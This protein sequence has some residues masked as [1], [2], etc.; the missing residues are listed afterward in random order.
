[1]GQDRKQPANAGREHRIRGFAAAGGIRLRL[2]AVLAFVIAAGAVAGAVFAARSV[3]ASSSAKSQEAFRHT[4]AEV[5]VRLQLAIQRENDLVVTAAGFFL[6]DP[7][8][9]SAQFRAW[10]TSIQALRR[11]P[12][13]LSWGVIDRVAA[14][15]VDAFAARFVSGPSGYAPPV[16]SFH[17]IPA[18][19]RP[20]YCLVAALQHRPTQPAA[21]AAL[22]YCAG[23][24]LAQ[25]A[26][27]GRPV[28]TAVDLGQGHILGLDVPFYRGGVVP[29]SASARRAAFAG[30]MGMSLNPSVVLDTALLGYPRTAV[31]FRF[32]SPSAGGAFAAS[33]AVFRAGTVAAHARSATISLHNGWTV[34][35][36]GAPAVSGIL[37]NRSAVWLLI[38]GILLGIVVGLLVMVLGTG[39]ARALRLVA[40][41]TGELRHQA[42]HDALTG[43]P[44]RTLIMDRI[45]QLLLRSR[46]DGTHGAALY[47]DLD[48][49]KNVNDSLGHE[50]GDRL[51]VAV[52]SRL[53]TALRAADT[54]GRM[55]G[56]EFVVLVGGA[57]HQVAPELVA[58]RLLDVMREPFVLEGAPA[59]IIINTSIGIAAGDRACAGDLLRDADVALYQAKAAGKNRYQTFNAEMQTDAAGDIKLEFDLR[60]ALEGEQF[61]L[62]YQPIYNLDDL[63]IVGVEALLRWHHPTEGVIGPDR[64]IPTLERTGQIREVGRWVLHKACEQVAAWHARGDT[65]DISVNVSAAQLNNGAI[66]DHIRG[67]LTI[68]GL[69][70]AS[71]IIEV[72]ETALMQNADATA[73]RLRAIKKLGVRIAVDDF[74]TG[75]SSLAYLQQFPVDCLKIDRIFTDAIAT[76]PESRALIG[77][78]VQLGKDLG[79]TTL[80]EGV[81]TPAQLDHLRS[82]GVDEIQGFLLSRPLDPHALETQI[83]EPTRATG[84]PR[85]PPRLPR[86]GTAARPPAAEPKRD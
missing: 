64:F 45:D 8:A 5:A 84:A 26:D 52:A 41:R 4:S 34:Q 85:K 25:L 36:L 61:R 33:S 18:G 19:Q 77:T 73:R 2:W 86:S 9:T 16:G 37:A 76:S 60:S 10:S 82:G 66:V 69:N 24:A 22:D 65:L 46:R 49:F 50:A 23:G 39:R 7:R 15:G 30:W 42:V 14:S 31:A 72:T 53:T 70:P 79:L 54:I 32:A 12:E 20:Y 3:A 75:Y 74:G 27:S 62:L 68:S 6:T 44:N 47:V 38:A 58:E 63:A 13:L 81:E 56:D 59:P 55:G 43:L 71:L 29:P 40:Q 83:L 78:L 21:P 17:P 35:V 1:M 48:E 57:D 28:Y 11:F 80:A 51:L 67:A